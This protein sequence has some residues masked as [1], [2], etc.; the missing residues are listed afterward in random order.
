MSSWTVAGALGIAVLIAALCWLWTIRQR[1]DATQLGMQALAAMSWQQ[2]SAAIEQALASR[3]LR[4]VD[5]E[6]PSSDA[7][8]SWMMEDGEQH[9]LLTCKHGASYRINAE[10]LEDL[11]QQARLHDANG[12]ILVTQGQLTAD[13][14]ATAKQQQ[15]QVLSGLEL[16][17]AVRNHL[18]PRVRDEVE[19]GARVRARRNSV[20]A[21]AGSLSLALVTATLLASPEAPSVRTT[22]PQPSSLAPAGSAPQAA[23]PEASLL[24]AATEA[25]LQQQRTDVSKALSASPGI[26]RGVWISKMTLVIDRQGEDAMVWPQV[27]SQLERHPGLRTS[28][29]QMNPPAG[30]SEPVRWRQCRT[31]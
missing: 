6:L 12:L 15:I 23:A 1:R 9:W 28:R 10:V 8:A 27:C 31:I 2:F 26:I 3:G 17:Q 13:G 5:D 4:T 24:P 21:A 7:Q 14:W 16:W 20:F 29:V 18:P 19:Q 25:Q 22:A 30:S 11:S